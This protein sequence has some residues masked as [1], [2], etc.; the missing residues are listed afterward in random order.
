MAGGARADAP[1]LILIE[2]LGVETILH[3]KAGQQTLLSA[4]SGM[5]GWRMGDAIQ[6]NIIRE[7]LHYFDPASQRRLLK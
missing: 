6:F 5:T 3:I 4:V 2:P 1:E 7:H